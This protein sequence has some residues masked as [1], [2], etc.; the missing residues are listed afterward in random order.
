MKNSDNWPSLREYL[1]KYANKD[2][3]ERAMKE[4]EHNALIEDFLRGLKM[5]N[6]FSSSSIYREVPLYEGKSERRMRGKIKRR[7]R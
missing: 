6:K 3:E 5:M 4:F 7:R 2:L 1:D